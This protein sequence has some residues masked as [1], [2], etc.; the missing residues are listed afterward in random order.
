MAG[1]SVLAHT[2]TPPANRT[3]RWAKETTTPII[4][5]SPRLQG[6]TPALSHSPFSIVAH[7]HEGR[8]HVPHGG[9]SFCLV[10]RSKEGSH[11]DCHSCCPQSGIWCV[12]HLYFGGP[13]QISPMHRLEVCFTSS[14]ADCVSFCGFIVEN[15]LLSPHVLVGCV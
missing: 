2:H 7:P 13:V 1:L 15:G 6:H 5:L 11:S 12:I 8:H 4:P 10:S 3:S 14:I 9:D